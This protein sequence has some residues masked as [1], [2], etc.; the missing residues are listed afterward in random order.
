MATFEAIEQAA[1]DALKATGL[2]D[3]PAVNIDVGIPSDR[4]VPPWVRALVTGIDFKKLTIN[5]YKAAI[6]L[7]VG[8][9]VK[10]LKGDRERR[11]KA[12]PVIRGVLLL[13]AGNRLGLDID[14]LVPLRANDTTPYDEESSVGTLRYQ[15]DFSTATQIT[16]P[17]A[18]AGDL[19]KLSVDYFLRPGDDVADTSDV[20]DLS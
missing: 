12:Y 3:I 13:L 11:E 17:E 10:N 20:H 14:P 7:S 16:V 9:E 1:V 5:K 18:D 8:I 19:L 2:S 6:V 4:N 15:I